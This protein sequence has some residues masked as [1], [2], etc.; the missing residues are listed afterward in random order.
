MRTARQ[1][2]NHVNV[3]QK[4]QAAKRRNEAEVVS[5]LQ[6][7]GLVFDT[8]IVFNRP[9]RNALKRLEARGVVKWGKANSRRVRDGFY[10]VKRK[11]QTRHAK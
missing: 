8:H 6:K 9:W 7:V 3:Y 2:R 1:H 5:H 10:L 4:I 11:T